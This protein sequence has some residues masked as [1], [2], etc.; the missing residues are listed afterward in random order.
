[1]VSQRRPPADSRGRLLAAAAQEFAACGFEGAKVDRIARRARVNKAMVYYH[2]RNKAALYREILRDVF[3]A[4]AAA[5]EAV[6]RTGGTPEAQLR[7]FIAAVAAAAAER[8]HFPAIWLREMADGGRH[9]DDSVV[10]LLRRVIRVL[11]T[12]LDDGRRAGAFRP[13]HP[14]VAQMGIVAPLLFFA[15]S[16]PLRARVHPETRRKSRRGAVAMDPISRQAVID[17]VQNTTLAAV[18]RP[19]RR[20]AR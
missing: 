16:A 6:R 14:F 2:F 19:A 10:A 15:A 20:R 8:P 3:G 18:R 7:G 5:V 13:I 12:M 9:L 4:A 17:H 1:M 11:A